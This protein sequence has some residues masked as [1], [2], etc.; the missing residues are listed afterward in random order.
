MWPF[1]RKP[2]NVV[3]PFAPMLEAMKAKDPA[4]FDVVRDMPVAA[5]IYRWRRAHPEDF[6]GVTS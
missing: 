2:K 5:G 1:K 4:L 6:E 3:Y